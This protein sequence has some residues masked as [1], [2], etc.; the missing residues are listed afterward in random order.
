VKGVLEG[1]AGEKKD[2]LCQAM[3]VGALVTRRKS[4]S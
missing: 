3:Q 4:L 1:K 2:E